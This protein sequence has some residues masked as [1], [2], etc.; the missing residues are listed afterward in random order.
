MKPEEQLEELLVQIRAIYSK[1]GTDQVVKAIA[2]YRREQELLKQEQELTEKV[3]DFTQKLD[4]VK[5][6]RK[7]KALE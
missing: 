2:E 4:A 6:Q 5:R 7:I 1:Y 3:L